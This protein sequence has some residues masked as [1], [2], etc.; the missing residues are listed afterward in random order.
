MRFIAII[1]GAASGLIDTAWV[2]PTTS[3]CGTVTLSTAISA[4]Q[5]RMIGTAK[6]RI[7]RDT[8]V[9]LAG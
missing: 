8:K 5:A 9:R 1:D 4:I 7:I 2:R 3:S 6:V